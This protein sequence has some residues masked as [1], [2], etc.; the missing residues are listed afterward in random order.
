MKYVV[1]IIDDSNIKKYYTNNHQSREELFKEDINKA[2][3][4]YSVTIATRVANQI[5]GFVEKIEAY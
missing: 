4:F 2:K 3:F 1:Y 5:D